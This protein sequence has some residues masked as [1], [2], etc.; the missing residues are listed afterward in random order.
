[1][2]W[3]CSGWRFHFT[4]RSESL[5]SWHGAFL[6]DVC[7]FSPSTQAP[8]HIP[9]TIPSLT[10]R[11]ELLKWVQV[12]VMLAEELRHVMAYLENSNFVFTEDGREA[13]SVE[14][15]PCHPSTCFCGKPWEERRHP[16]LS[17]SPPSISRHSVRS[18]IICMRSSIPLYF[19][20]VWEYEASGPSMRFI[21]VLL[22]RR[23]ATSIVTAV[24]STE[25]SLFPSVTVT[26][27]SWQSGW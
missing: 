14:V 15:L 26:A 21:L 6:C 11:S 2:T 7:G 12:V 8:A 25:Y 1:M 18:D 27:V 19:V 5:F 23:A 9:K 3:W 24:P 13:A 10:G 4:Q 16:T 20:F 22:F 17:N